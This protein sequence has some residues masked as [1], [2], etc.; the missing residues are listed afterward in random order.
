MPKYGIVR[1]VRAV[2]MQRRGTVKR[3]LQHVGHLRPRARAGRDDRA[4]AARCDHRVDLFRKPLAARAA[5]HERTAVAADQ[6]AEN[7]PRQVARNA[8]PNDL[9]RP[10]D[11]A[12]ATPCCVIRL[13]T[14]FGSRGS[15]YCGVVTTRS[16]TSRRAQVRPRNT[17]RVRP[18]LHCLI[19]RHTGSFFRPG[20]NDDV[21]PRRCE[22]V[23]TRYVDAAPRYRADQSE[24]S[25]PSVVT[26]SFRR[27]VAAQ[28]IREPGNL[29]VFAGAI[30]CDGPDA[31]RVPARGFVCIIAPRQHPPQSITTL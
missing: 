27:D 1:I 20:G 21:G 9:A 13:C 14:T 24:R 3:R 11:A 7:R 17:S 31:G 4:A 12:S 28:T 19:Q 8:L 16:N 10:R 25:R 30:A 6:H 29:R 23:G 5:H 15:R 22:C 26:Q 2:S 18:P